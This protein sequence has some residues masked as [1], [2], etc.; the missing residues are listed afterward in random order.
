MKKRKK[1]NNNKQLLI[2]IIALVTILII[3]L[4]IYAATS[5][6]GVEKEL[7]QEGYTTTTDNAFY[8]KVVTNNTLDDFYSDMSQNKDSA[9]E[10]Y[11]FAKESLN[12]IE[13]KMQYQDNVNSTLNITSDLRTEKVEFNYELSSKSSHLIIEGNSDENYDCKIVVNKNVKDSLLTESCELVMQEI[14]I[15]LQRRSDLLQNESIRNIVNQPIKEYVE[16]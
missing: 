3:A 7:N 8:N 15:F 16:E 4:L 12:F 2:G 1:E 5:K 14:T 9:Y 13:L 11:Y 6:T 10:E